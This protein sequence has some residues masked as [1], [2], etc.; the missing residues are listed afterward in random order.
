M[1]TI[2][3]QQP[4]FTKT[5][6]LK[7]ISACWYFLASQVPSNSGLQWYT[8]ACC[9]ETH[10]LMCRNIDQ[11]AST[12]SGCCMMD[13]SPC[14]AVNYECVPCRPFY[15]VA[16]TMWCLDIRMAIPCKGEIPCLVTNMGMTFLYNWDIKLD[17]CKTIKQLQY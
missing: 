10:G 12:R 16:C 13:L 11:V 9:C 6:D 14:Y 15:S 17:C 1:S 8:G 3:D 2:L 4:G 7:P 5:D